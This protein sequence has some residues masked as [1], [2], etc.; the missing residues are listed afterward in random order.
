MDIHIYRMLYVCIWR[1]EETFWSWICLST[2]MR[3]PVIKVRSLGF[4]SDLFHLVSCSW[5]LVLTNGS[6]CCIL[7]SINSSHSGLWVLLY[8]P[9]HLTIHLD[10]TP[11]LE[12]KAVLCMLLSSLWRWNKMKILVSLVQGYSL[13]K[14]RSIRF[15]CYSL[16]RN[17]FS[18][19]R[20]TTEAET[21]HQL[22]S[23]LPEPPDFPCRVLTKISFKQVTII[24]L[25]LLRETVGV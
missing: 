21:V 7:G 9:L 17:H 10:K 2:F 16:R 13:W 3:V 22:A 8:A 25:L 15:L 23:L 5:N 12:K 18:Q 1:T 4:H 14:D 11:R 19:T 20:I 6:W 24:W